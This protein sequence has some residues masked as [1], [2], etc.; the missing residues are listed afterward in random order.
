MVASVVVIVDMADAAEVAEAVVADL[1][2]GAVVEVEDVV[3]L[4]AAHVQV[5][6]PNSLVQNRSSIKCSSSLPLFLSL[7]LHATLFTV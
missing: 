3:L 1:I 2:V 7:H 5:A 6:S 4:E